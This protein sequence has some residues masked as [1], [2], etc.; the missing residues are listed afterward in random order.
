VEREEHVDKSVEDW[1]LTEWAGIAVAEPEHVRLH[2]VP[3]TAG[4]GA[5]GRSLGS[6]DLKA[7]GAEVRA[8]RRRGIRGDDPTDSLVLEAGDVIVLRGTSEAIE[9][10]DARLLGDG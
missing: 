2:S 10:A 9:L 6:L 3:L 1:A 7:T 5:I 4:S 8:V